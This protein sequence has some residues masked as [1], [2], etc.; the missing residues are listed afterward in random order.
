[1]GLFEF[2]L[3]SQAAP[4][5][6]PV[7]EVTSEILREIVK[8]MDVSEI[9]IVHSFEKSGAIEI[10]SGN[11]RVIAPE[12]VY[13]LK[14]W[15]A[16]CSETRIRT[17]LDLSRWLE[18]EGIPVAPALIS[19][20]KP[21]CVSHVGRFW[22]VF[23][24]A[25]GKYYGGHT[26]ELK[27]V[28]QKIG[29]LH[30]ALAVAPTRLLSLG[31]GPHYRTDIDGAILR[32]AATMRGEWDQIFGRELALLLRR[33]WSSVEL[34]WSQVL[35]MPS[36]SGPTQ[37]A[38]FD[39][40]PHNI[41]MAEGNVSA[42]L[43]FDSCKQMQL[44]YA[45]GF[46]GLKL[47]RQAVAESRGGVSPADAG[48]RFLNTLCACDSRFEVLADLFSVRASTEVLRRICGILRLNIE[49]SQKTWNHVLPVQLCH[50]EE[51]RALFG[52]AKF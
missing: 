36:N 33:S 23:P 29:Q 43:D 17:I 16:N 38:H 5:W 42:F 45:L 40:H 25:P 22:S 21:I 31:A 49:K 11:F 9:S 18:G 37:L 47:G 6:T 35:R 27:A 52:E 20:D 14:Q 39:L 7:D 51:A 13:L 50:L 12:G 24:F 44:G 41:L 2:D 26:N 10:N 32:Q 28:A 1:M 19:H 3:F 48:S 46:A 15:G 8:K 34:A 4:V 30:M